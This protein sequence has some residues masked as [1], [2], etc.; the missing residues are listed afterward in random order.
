MQL[1]SVYNA[2]YETSYTYI[3]RL[4]SY[5]FARYSIL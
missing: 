1:V 2:T 3:V 4:A 5:N